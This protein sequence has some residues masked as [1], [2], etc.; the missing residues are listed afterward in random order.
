MPYKVTAPVARSTAY[1][2]NAQL[3][4]SHLVSEARVPE[5]CAVSGKGCKE[6][7]DVF[8]HEILF[9]PVSKLNTGNARL[10]CSSS[11]NGVRLGQRLV[12]SVQNCL[13]Q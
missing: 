1:D 12:H 8:P 4:K 2:F 7:R 3:S 13:R 6:A 10:R 11:L 5:E 9:E